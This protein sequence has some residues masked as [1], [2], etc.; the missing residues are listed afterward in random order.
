MLLYPGDGSTSSWICDCM[1]RF[2]YFPL[3]GTC[4]EAYRQGPCPAEHHVILPEGESVPKC[5]KNPCLDD[6]LV[7]YNN[8]CYALKTQGGPCAPLG[9]LIVNETNF[10]IECIPA[11]IAPFVIIQAPLLGCPLG[12]R[13]NRLGLCKRVV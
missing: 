11:K 7:S 9:V 5:V 10:Q 8:T 6:S 12:S 4:H 2:L 13:R 3:N 1:P